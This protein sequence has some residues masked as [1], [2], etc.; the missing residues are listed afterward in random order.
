MGPPT[1]TPDWH[2]GPEKETHQQAKT[3]IPVLSFFSIRIAASISPSYTVP[4]STCIP[5]SDH[6]EGKESQVFQKLQGEG[7]AQVERT[8][9]GEAKEEERGK[10]AVGK[11]KWREHR[12][13]S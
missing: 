11:S 8:G 6:G 1:S 12:E 3:E 5:T 9:K 13:R 2:G 7:P 4:F 10:G